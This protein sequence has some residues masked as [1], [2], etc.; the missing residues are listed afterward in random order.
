MVTSPPR[1]YGIPAPEPLPETTRLGGIRLQVSDLGRSAAYY[2][3]VLGLRMIEQSHD[4]IALGP[5]DSTATLVELIHRP[6]AHPVPRSGLLGLYHFAILLP[7]RAALGRFV[8]HLARRGHAFASADHLVS[9]AIY[10]WDP[11]GLGIEV[12]ADRPR[13]RWQVRARELMMAT[14]PLDLR[15]LVA[16]GETAPWNGM[17]EGTVMGHMHLSIGDLD[18]G[19]RFYHTA[20]GLDVMVWSYP[21]ALFLAAG[22]YHH[23]LG[24]NTWAGRARPAGDDDA[25]LL[26]WTLVL[27]TPDAVARAADRLRRAGSEPRPVE[28]GLEI[29]DPWGSTVCLVPA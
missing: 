27:P 23:H 17:P 16:G 20:L 3:D 21:G 24:T 9:E 22:G 28:S 15:D 7:T 19:R 12:Y 2:T 10:L 14:D 1:Q 11:D 26:S 13:D 5:A 8:A 4:R 25:R 18:E 29:V 6:G